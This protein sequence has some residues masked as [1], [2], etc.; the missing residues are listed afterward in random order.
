MHEARIFGS[1]LRERRAELG[2]TRE[3]LA[4]RVGCSVVMLRKLEADQRKPSTELAEA[5]AEALEIDRENHADFLQCARVSV[6]VGSTSTKG[7]DGE[8]SGTAPRGPVHN[9][10]VQSTSL[11]GREQDVA[12]VSA[13]VQD[14]GSRLLT[15]TGPPGVGKTRLG[16]EVAWSLTNAFSDGVYFVPLAPVTEPALVP[17]EVAKALALEPD[18][19]RTGLR[20]LLAALRQKHTLLLL[21]NCEQVDVAPALT[22]LLAGCRHVKLLVTSRSPVNIRG[23]QLY[24]VSPLEL[25][26]RGYVRDAHELTG[27][28]ATSLFLERAQLVTPGFSLTRSDAAAVAEICTRLDGLPLAIELVAA[29][30]RL[31]GP[32]ALLERLSGAVAPDRTT[33]RTAGRS[34]ALLT[35]GPQ[36]LPD[37]LRTLRSA[38]SWSYDLLDAGDRTVFNRLAAFVDGCTPEAAEVVCSSGPA[39]SDQSSEAPAVLDRLGSLADKSLMQISQ[40]PGGGTRL[41]MLETIREYALE[42]LES[43]GEHAR[44]R[45]RHALY[46]IDLVE[47]FQPRLFGPDQAEALTGLERE[48][49]NVRAA[50]GWLERSGQSELALQ[51]ATK[52]WRYWLLRG[53]LEEGRRWLE[54]LLASSGSVASHSRAAG[55]IALGELLIESEDYQGARVSFEEGLALCRELGDAIRA[56]T[57]LTNLGL[58]ASTLGDHG[59]AVLLCG[60]ALALQRR[61]HHTRGAALSLNV[62]ANVAVHNGDYGRAIHLLEECLVRR[63]ELGDDASVAGTLGNLG[64]LASWRGDHARA[65]QLHE[66]CVGLRRALGNR[67]GIAVALENLGATLLMMGERQGA[68]RCL[69]E[70]LSLYREFGMSQG[71]ASVHGY[72][73][74]MLLL[75]G[76]PVL[77]T[78]YFVNGLALLRDRWSEQG[79]ADLWYAE[80]ITRCIEGLAAAAI[81]EGRSTRGA[82]MLGAAEAARQNREMPVPPPVREH[83]D[84]MEA[85]A[86]EGLGGVHFALVHAEGRAMGPQ[87]A[88]EY[89]LTD[90]PVSPARDERYLWQ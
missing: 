47:A 2:V 18:G 10:P 14:P 74:W 87:E 72:L 34:L 5:L 37:R 12:L 41:T 78:E 70:S 50:L 27:Y 19:E 24:T 55:L 6:R 32:R 3:Q 16:L 36:D 57:T 83:L 17:A 82:R 66:E 40:L 49:S 86:R 28:P 79:S 63:R 45:Q 25:P 60:E 26:P 13:R 88:L 67:T 39:G 89:A 77:A 21:D 9:L 33:D 42:Q 59:R 80:A 4:A 62:L 46:Y 30:S 7:A 64:L 84:S 65:R 90:E 61:E 73:G 8:A 51:L 22:D 35:Q 58:I 1:W 71:A 38:I 29:R 54:S 15:L 68:T 75:D 44:V 69:E 81:G 76:K 48:H 52:L 85:Q 43:A 11:L 20:Q 23:E 56:A 31:L 53:H